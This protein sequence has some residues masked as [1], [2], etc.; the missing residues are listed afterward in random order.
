[1]AESTLQSK[2]GGH[3]RLLRWALF[4]VL[5]ISFVLVALYF[6]VSSSAFV[7]GVLLPRMGK[8]YNAEITAQ[9]AVLR[10]FS[11][12]TLR[13]LNVRS[14]GTEPVLQA[15]ELHARFRLGDLLA[16]RN[17]LEEL[18]LVN[19][20][21]HVLEQPDGSRNVDPL[22]EGQTPADPDETR[23]LAWHNIAIRN[24]TVYWT[25]LGGEGARTDMVW[26]GMEAHLDRLANDAAG[27]FTFSS[28]META[29]ARPWGADQ[30]QAELYGTAEFD[31]G[32][33]LE[34]RSLRIT[35]TN[36]VTDAGGAWADLAGY[37]AVVEGELVPGHL[38]RLSA[39][40]LRNGELLGQIRASGPVD[41]ERSE[42]A[43]TVVVDGI[44]HPL[45]NL[46]GARW[47]LQFGDS[48]LD[49]TLD[50]A[51]RDGGSSMG[52]SGRVNSAPLRLTRAGQTTPAMDLHASFETFLQQDEQRARLDSF[53]LEGRQ[54]GQVIIEAGLSQPVNLSW[55]EGFM[56]SDETMVTM[57]LRRLSVTD[58]Q[59]FLDR[60]LQE[61]DSPAW[62]ATHGWLEASQ[63][64]RL[65]HDRADLTGTARLSEF[66]GRC[67]DSAFDGLDVA[68][69][70]DASLVGSSLELRELG[71][72]VQHAQVPSGSLRLGGT[73]H[74][75]RQEGQ[76]TLAVENLDEQILGPVLNP[77][78]APQ[79]ILRIV[80]NGSGSVEFGPNDEGRLRAQLQV[81]D[82]VT[83][84][85][86][87]QPQ[88]TP[89]RAELE[90]N[91][92]WRDN[93]YSIDQ[94]VLQMA[95][96]SRADNQVRLR[97]TLD[98]SETGQEP[99]RLELYAA[100][101]DLTPIYDLLSGETPATTAPDRSPDQQEA[102]AEP[103]PVELPLRQLE[104]DARI[105]RLYLRDLVI[106]DLVAVTTLDGT[107]ARIEPLTG[108]IHGAP[109]SGRLAMDLGT[110]GWRYDLVL[111]GEAIPVEPL[112]N[113]FAPQYA[114]QY[115]GLLQA[116]IALRGQGITTASLQRHLEGQVSIAFT[117]AQIQLI[118]PRV[119][120]LLL[121]IASLLRLPQLTQSPLDWLRLESR[122][123]DGQIQVDELALQSV[124]FR[125]HTAGTIP[126]SL[127]PGR[128][129]LNLP[130][131]FQL[132]RALAEKARLL[133]SNVPPDVQ[134]I[135]LP[136]FAVVRG[137]LSDP[138]TELDSGA[139]TRLLLQSG[140]GI[141]EKQGIDIDDSAARVLRGIGDILGGQRL[142]LPSAPPPGQSEP[143]TNQTPRFPLPAP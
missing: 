97:G 63:T 28:R 138:R 62:S 128:A 94:A 105:E 59:P 61:F 65:V 7:R 123:S 32:P 93:R 18:T 132:R 98:L 39:Q 81:A 111:G 21:F 20:V 22:L 101:L 51:V 6:T 80:L 24:G 3:R 137:S 40:F 37:R 77:Y 71:V 82:L 66:T 72:D 134:Y 55:A 69:R 118:Q 5:A 87:Q 129:T 74:L 92:T 75:E 16:N 125:A 116:D 96:T 43:V 26:T 99:S 104:M 115:R 25:R 9:E 73:M 60:M 127:E 53:R 109:V 48:R 126:L 78:F 17:R 110:P 27:R 15:D 84:A 57:N 121:P 52:L 113:S 4:A 13:G 36:I 33:G 88:P 50:L 31:L 120:N 12:L 45:L 142:Q 106:S 136:D 131:R 107:L 30:L 64:F 83:T 117:D 56:V 135:A 141:A 70:V 1:M 79:S 114:G 139:I 34:P 86:A 29:V 143:E 108:S 89:F 10:P 8:G 91:T 76:F 54:E 23:E 68:A 67:G 103:E 41:L 35:S 122:I 112:V 124:A 2:E 140:I 95:P 58:W 11:S 44:G 42:A 90:L 119:Q 102:P 47:D 130:I 49:A 38:D 85:T 133:P 14:A 46:V 19:P 100:A